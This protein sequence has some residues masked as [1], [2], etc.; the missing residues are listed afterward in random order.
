MI[1]AW[2]GVGPAS[3]ADS[4]PTRVITLVVPY[5]ADGPPD[6]TGRILAESM[7]AALG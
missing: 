5:A 6:T 1:A 3:A 2:L 7:S 4:Y